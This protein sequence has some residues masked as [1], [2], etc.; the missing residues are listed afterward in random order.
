MKAAAKWKQSPS[1]FCYFSRVLC[2][3]REFQT[4]SRSDRTSCSSIIQCTTTTFRGML[5]KD[6]TV[7]KKHGAKV[8]LDFCW[9]VSKLTI[10]FSKGRM[11]RISTTSTI[12]FWF[13]PANYSTEL[14]RSW[15]SLTVSRKSPRGTSRPPT[16][17]RQAMLELSSTYSAK[18]CSTTSTIT[19][20]YSSRRC[21]FSSRESQL[22]TFKINITA[23]RGFT[24]A[25]ERTTTL[26]V[27][28]LYN[29]RC[30]SLYR[31]RKR[32][33]PIKFIIY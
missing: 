31:S 29:I 8:C 32:K 7:T 33:F 30:S 21:L 2:P 28:I 14:T 18:C 23:R 25:Q 1:S 22:I 13:T 11:W 6:E 4:T 20:R 24:T 5:T 27:Y 10:C 9:L 12:R 19:W 15:T 17:S 3:W 26:T 16:S